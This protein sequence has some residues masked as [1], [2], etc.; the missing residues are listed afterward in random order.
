MAQTD[1]A[2]VDPYDREFF[3]GIFIP[4][5]EDIEKNSH[6]LFTMA[7]TYYTISSEH[8]IN[9]IAGIGKFMLLQ[10][11][12]ERTNHLQQASNTTL[13]TSMQITQL[14]QDR[15]E[16]YLVLT[17][18]RQAEYATYMESLTVTQL[19]ELIG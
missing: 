5:T 12:A 7:R 9:Q 3:L 4:L 6:L 2:L 16:E 13:T 17:H 15:H 18:Q 14:A 8:M 19:G 10:T 11:D 1:K